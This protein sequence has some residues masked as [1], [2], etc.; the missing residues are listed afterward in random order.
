MIESSKLLEKDFK[1]VGKKKIYFTIS[2]LII[3]I[4]LV[5]GIICSLVPGAGGFFNKGFDMTG[6]Y[7]MNVKIFELTDENF[8]EN[9][10]KLESVINDQTFTVDGKS[11][12]VR[13]SSMQFLN[14]DSDPCIRVFYTA[15]ASEEEMKATVNP[16]LKSAV[17]Q[18]FFGG[19]ISF[20][21][22]AEKIPSS[23]DAGTVVMVAGALAGAAVLVFVY[24]II[25]FKLASA[26]IA[27]MGL[28]HDMMLTLAIA[29]ICRMELGLYFVPALAAVFIFS[30]ANSLIYF[31]R[32]RSE[33]KN[34]NAKSAPSAFAETAV[35]KSILTY[36]SIAVVAVLAALTLTIFGLAGMNGAAMYIAPLLVGVIVS[37]YSSIFFVPSLWTVFSERGM[38]NARK[39]KARKK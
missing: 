10:D 18:D 24:C 2:A 33:K 32:I 19:A 14:K 27:A 7:A 25:R 15:T 17:E 11:A 16:A 6:G 5:V 22:E 34:K 21:G 28:I 1:I 38:Q 35:K 8:N 3:L 30:I 26:L 23:M 4:A 9:A 20:V 31:D 13:V 39:A 37:M 12:K 36:I 29:V